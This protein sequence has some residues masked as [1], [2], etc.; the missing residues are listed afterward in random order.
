MGNPQNDCESRHF[1][2]RGQYFWNMFW[3]ISPFDPR[4]SALFIDISLFASLA[5]GAEGAKTPKSVYTVEP[6]R[7]KMRVQIGAEGAKNSIQIG[8]ETLKNTHT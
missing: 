5:Q 2:S 7:S 3:G 1:R 4:R 6:K 8:A